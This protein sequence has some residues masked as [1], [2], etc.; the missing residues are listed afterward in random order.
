MIKKAKQT[1]V[2][3]DVVEQ[4]QDAIL[5]GKLEPGSN[6]WLRMASCICSTTS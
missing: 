3:Q 4:I 6:L 2:F 5:N 1:R